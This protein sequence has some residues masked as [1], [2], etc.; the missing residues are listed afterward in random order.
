MSCYRAILN[1]VKICPKVG[2]LVCF[3]D[4]RAAKNSQESGFEIDLFV[5]SAPFL[6]RN[7]LWWIQDY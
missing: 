2:H 7:A 4:D 6:N 1:L 5:N 3:H